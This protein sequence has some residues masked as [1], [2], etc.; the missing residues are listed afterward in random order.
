MGADLYIQSEFRKA[1]NA[2]RNESRRVH[3]E[4]VR[5]SEKL[6]VQKSEE[7]SLTFAVRD[8]QEINT[9]TMGLVTEEQLLECGKRADELD[10]LIYSP[11]HYFRDSY[12]EGSLLWSLGL[13]WWQDIGGLIDRFPAGPRY[14]ESEDADNGAYNEYDGPNLS[15]EGVKEFLRLIANRPF[16]IDKEALVASYNKARAFFASGVDINPLFPTR[17]W[18]QDYASPE[19]YLQEVIAY[20]KVR[21]DTL[22]AFL[23]H[24]IDLNEGIYCSI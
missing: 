24:A 21:R 14:D 23:Q 13:S 11:S 4:W 16:A 17:D 8:G 7:G 6:R 2:Y 3:G 15:V 10:S 5:L 19:E 1:E 9:E 20:K 22:V 18:T 12:N